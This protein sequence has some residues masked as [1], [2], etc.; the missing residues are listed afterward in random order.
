MT[1]IEE[2]HPTTFEKYYSTPKE[3]NQSIVKT[4]SRNKEC[5]NERN[6]FHV[7]GK[8]EEDT[9]SSLSHGTL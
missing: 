5:R 4:G 8:N 9:F 6:Y 1:R 3:V 2:F 7:N